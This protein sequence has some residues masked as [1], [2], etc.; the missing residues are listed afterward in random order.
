MKPTSKRGKSTPKK[1][2]KLTDEL[3]VPWVKKLEQIDSL[4]RSNHGELSINFREYF[5]SFCKRLES[6]TTYQIREENFFVAMK[7][8]HNDLNQH[9]KQRRNDNQT[10][11]DVNMNMNF[12]DTPDFFRNIFN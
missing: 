9:K 10:D 2:K 12:N 6:E 8:Y 3:V 5:M 4:N 11:Q 1:R 7:Y